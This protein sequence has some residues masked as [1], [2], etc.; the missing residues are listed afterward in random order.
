[1]FNRES[2]ALQSGTTAYE[3][4]LL[5]GLVTTLTIG[6]ACVYPIWDDARLLYLVDKNGIEAIGWS[7]GFRP[8]VASIFRLLFDRRLLLPVTLVVHWLGWLG[9]GLVTMRFWKLMFPL[10]SKLALLPALLSVTPIL[11]KIQLV[12]FTVVFVCLVGPVF[13]Y[14]GMFLL[15]SNESSRQR[16]L[17]HDIA[18]LALMALAVMLSEYGALTATVGFVLL[19]SKAIRT[20]KERK[21]EPAIIAIL[22]AL[23]ALVSYLI[24][25]KIGTG[26]NPGFLPSY[27][28]QYLSGKVTVIP[29]RLL[30]ALWRGAMGGFIESLGSIRLDSKVALL[31]F[32]CGAALA[33]LVVL[34]IHKPPDA[35]AEFHQY[36]PTVITLLVATAVA[37]IPVFLMARTIETRWDSRF[38]LPMLPVL[39]SLT[40]FTLLTMIR[41]RLWT[42][43]LILCGFLAGYWTSAEIADMSKPRDWVHGFPSITATAHQPPANRIAHDVTRTPRKSVVRVCGP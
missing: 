16:K 31:S 2:H 15:L 33:G 36:W 1:M 40:V 23:S 20:R 27:S 38:F 12:T 37:L 26:S 10:Y 42:V 43:V 30:S 14:L 35:G 22:L 18:G 13:G 41:Q 34:V 39:S 28:L 8:V 25:L 3:F 21:R 24:F 4:L 32:V 19:I 5:A 29:F 9:L 17:V 7:F 6:A 11:C